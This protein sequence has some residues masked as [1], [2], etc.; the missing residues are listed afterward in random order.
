VVAADIAIYADGPAK[1]TGGCG[2]VAMLIGPDAPL[3]IDAQLRATHASN[4][5]DF[6]K[7]KFASEYPEVRHFPSPRHEKRGTIHTYAE[8]AGIY[9]R[10]QGCGA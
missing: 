6:F 9:I 7:P 2:A 10:R 8:R 5:W 3:V 1:P 4:T